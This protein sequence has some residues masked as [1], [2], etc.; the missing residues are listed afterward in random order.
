MDN[1]K[2]SSRHGIYI[3][4]TIPIHMNS[5]L[6]LY[7]YSYI[8]FKGLAQITM[9]TMPLITRIKYFQ[10][11]S[12]SYIY[13]V[14][15]SSRSEQHQFEKSDLREEKQ[16]DPPFKAKTQHNPGQSNTLTAVIYEHD[17]NN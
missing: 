7:N 10:K 11:S 6:I 17:E 9:M 5:L 13:K 1:L 4:L 16:D 12:N 15:T 3:I 2:M 14:I 8:I